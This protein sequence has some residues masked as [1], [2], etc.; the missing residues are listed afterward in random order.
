MIN[1]LYLLRAATE[2][3]ADA[4][5]FA[6]AWSALVQALPVYDTTKHK[7]P[8][9]LPAVYVDVMVP[10]APWAVS[11]V[12]IGRGCH[13]FLALPQEAQNYCYRQHHQL[14]VRPW[15]VTPAAQMT[16]YPAARP[17]SSEGYR[18]LRPTNTAH[19]DPTSYRGPREFLA[20]V[21][22]DFRRLQAQVHSAA[23]AAT[24]PGTNTDIT[25]ELRKYVNRFHVKDRRT[26]LD[27]KLT[28]ANHHSSGMRFALTFQV[29]M[30]K[31][32]SGPPVI[33]AVAQLKFTNTR[34]HAAVTTPTHT[35]H[36]GMDVTTDPR[37]TAQEIILMCVMDIQ[38]GYT[39]KLR[40]GNS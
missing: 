29:R 26:G 15:R 9:K 10:D 11:V 30:P 21:L 34:R 20:A 33:Q 17:G 8:A 40:A 14:P 12:V 22:S 4:A 35:V 38:R 1:A 24:E 3:Q 32:V 5:D 6:G 31:V 36:H 16:F 23:Q 28:G 19:Y 13:A 39:E 2:P 25:A 18:D 37:G 7:R 27:V